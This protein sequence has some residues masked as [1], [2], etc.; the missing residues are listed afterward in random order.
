MNQVYKEEQGMFRQMV[1]KVNFEQGSVASYVIFEKKRE[2]ENCKLV[3][4]EF[5]Q[6][7]RY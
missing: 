4:L 5:S 6:A 3:V 1:N 7:K 2:Q